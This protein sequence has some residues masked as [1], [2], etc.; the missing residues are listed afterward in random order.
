MSYIF[1]F[2][3]PIIAPPPSTWR[4][5]LNLL[6]NIL[7]CRTFKSTSYPKVKVEVLFNRLKA[8][9][10]GQLFKME[11]KFRGQFSLTAWWLSGSL[12]IMLI[13]SGKSPF[14]CMWI[15]WRDYFIQKTNKLKKKCLLLSWYVYIYFFILLATLCGTFVTIYFNFFL[16]ATS[17][18]FSS[19]DPILAR[20]NKRSVA[21]RLCFRS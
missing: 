14:F 3:F 5:T 21:F 17:F 20:E 18:V 9:F 13:S 15:T 1:I 7:E 8:S 6:H 16:F 11:W 2:F 10:H 12:N 4:I 19:K